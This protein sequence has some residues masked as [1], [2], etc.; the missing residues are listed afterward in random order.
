MNCVGEYLKLFNNYPYLSA[1]FLE[2]L[3]N[4]EKILIKFRNLY[5]WLK[6]YFNSVYDVLSIIKN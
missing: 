4:V 2:L 5:H 3:D 6:Y 1:T